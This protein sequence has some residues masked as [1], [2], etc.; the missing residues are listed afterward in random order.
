MVLNVVTETAEIVDRTPR[1]FISSLL[2]RYTRDWRL[3][4]GAS[5]L[6]HDHQL[7]EALIRKGR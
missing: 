6:Q 5:V 4:A 1:V 7:N 2:T 3:W